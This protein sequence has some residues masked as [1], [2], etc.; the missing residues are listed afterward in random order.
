M[1]ALERALKKARQTKSVCGVTRRG[2]GRGYE[3]RE[4]IDVLAHPDLAVLADEIERLH[5]DRCARQSN[6]DRLRGAIER[7]VKE[8]DAK[9]LDAHAAELSNEARAYAQAETLVRTI[10]SGDN[11]MFNLDIQTFFANVKEED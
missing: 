10:L 9:G 8:L 3:S 5:R 6:A 7:V 11:E 4:P 2:T 1:N